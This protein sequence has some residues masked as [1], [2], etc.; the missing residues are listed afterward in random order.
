MFI[1]FKFRSAVSFDVVD[2]GDRTA[3]SVGE[4][5]S[6]VIAQKNLKLCDAFDLV[7]SDH[8]SGQEYN[9]EN[10]QI[11][12]NSSVIIKRV[13]AGSVPSPLPFDSTENL[14][15]KKLDV[16]QEKG[17]EMHDFDDFGTDLCPVPEKIFPYTDLECK[18]KN[19]CET[20]KAN[21]V[22]PRLGGQKLQADD[23]V[24]VIR[25]DA[26]LYGTKGKLPP[27]MLEPKVQEHGKPGKKA[28]DP[29]DLAEKNAC[30]PSELRCS[31]C[32]K[33]LKQAVMIPC[34]HHSFCERCIR[35]VLSEKSKCPRC[36]SDKF[37]A[38]DLLPNLS[39]REAI[40][41]FLETQ[42]QFSISETALRRYAPDEESGIQANDIS[43]ALPIFQKRQNNIL[44]PSATEKGSNH[45]LGDS[46]HGDSLIKRE[47]HHA[48]PPSKIGYHPGFADCQGEN[49]PLD[50]PQSYAQEKGEDRKVSATAIYK[51]ADKTCYMC[52]SPDHFIRD[53][54]FA[55]GPHPLL[56]TGN[57]MYAMGARP[58]FATPYWNNTAF[59]P[60]RPFTNIY[61]NHGMMPYNASMFPVSPIGVSPY[62]ASMYGHMPA[63]SSF[64]RM[65]GMSPLAGNTTENPFTH[66]DFSETQRFKIRRNHSKEYMMRRQPSDDDDIQTGHH[67]LPKSSQYL[68]YAERE[69]SGSYSGDKHTQR[70][71]GK[72]L[73]DEH[74]DRNAHSLHDGHGKNSRS[75]TGTR[76]KKAYHAQRSNSGAEYMSKRSDRYGDEWHNDRH[77]EITRNHYKRR[78]HFGSDSNRNERRGQKD[79]KVY[80]DERAISKKYG[81]HFGSGE[82]PSFSGDRKKR[83]REGDHR[84]SSKHSRDGTE[85]IRNDCRSKKV[86][87]D[88]DCG[89]DNY[90]L[91]RKRVH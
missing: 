91:K 43:T 82:E 85:D 77:H 23:L 31:I 30:L 6:K 47:I 11:P 58:A 29:Y 79:K 69:N 48:R 81:S 40:V 64:P 4:L 8:L 80:S 84:R 9:D 16:L 38:E 57:S 10:Y 53:C 72:D 42:I 68:F 41:H 15:M 19:I 66:E 18:R 86:R 87:W 46:F 88:E 49:N 44:Y 1:R 60:M 20:E 90:Q 61:P 22:V 14:A 76:D 2:I 24:E 27:E 78:G 26:D 54:P 62:M 7:F 56:Q 13:P 70:S 50:L 83:R 45:L 89:E 67:N 75:S 71:R 59:G 52:D 36:S 3:I 35:E 5:K 17:G 12:S 74:F 63:H 33:Y 55:N 37:K 21:I 39:L 25:K 51:K 65:A 32:T 73:R 28:M 34:C